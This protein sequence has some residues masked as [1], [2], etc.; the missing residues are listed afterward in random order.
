MSAD[1]HARSYVRARAGVTHN[2]FT[3]GVGA[4][5]EYYGPLQQNENNFGAFLQVA[6]F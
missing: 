4:S 5:M 1:L 3:F 2:E 6:L